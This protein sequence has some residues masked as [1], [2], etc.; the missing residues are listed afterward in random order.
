MTRLTRRTVVQAGAVA[1]GGMAIDL[2]AFIQQAS[3]QTQA[4]APSMALSVA[5]IKVAPGSERDI[6]QHVQES[7]VP[8]VSKESGF[9]DF[10]LVSTP[11]DEV[12][13]I[14]MFQD[15]K[16]AEAFTRKTLGWIA[17]TIAKQVHGSVQFTT[18]QVLVHKRA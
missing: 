18:G 4:P 2:F 17:Q 9:L 12:T 7:F 16:A 15:Q 5:R 1:V 8:L 6:A 3:A 14:S 10:Y 13:M 11:G